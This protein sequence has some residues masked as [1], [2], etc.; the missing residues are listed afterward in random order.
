MVTMCAC[1]ILPCYISIMTVFLVVPV[2]FIVVGIIKF[3]DFPIDS[4]IPIWMISIAGAIL[5]ERVVEAIKT[6][7][8]KQLSAVS[9]HFQFTNNERNAMDSYSGIHLFIVPYP[10]PSTV[11]SFYSSL[12]FAVYLH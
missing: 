5:L 6:M 11:F 1:C 7:G 3:N 8:D 2:L 12:V 4:R 10:L 9:S